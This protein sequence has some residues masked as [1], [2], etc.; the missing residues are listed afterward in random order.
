[1]TPEQ[2]ILILNLLS[3]G[4]LPSQLV[5]LLTLDTDNNY[6]VLNNGL[7]DAKKIKV[8]LLRGF[9]GSY[10]ANTNTPSLTNGV[11][12]DGDMHLVSVAGSR[13]FGAGTVNLL[14]DDIIIYL[15]GKYLKT[16]ANY[17]DQDLNTTNNVTFNS[18][19]TK[20]MTLDVT[21]SPIISFLPNVDVTGQLLL[22]DPL[23]SWADVSVNSNS[24]NV[25]GNSSNRLFLVDAVNSNVTIDDATLTFLEGVHRSVISHGGQTG[26]IALSLP[27]SSGTLALTTAL[28]SYLLLTG[29]TLTGDLNIDDNL[30]TIKL[31]D[32]DNS[33]YGRIRSSNGSLTFEADEG[34][35]QAD[36]FIKFE[37][38]A[39]ERMRIDSTGNV[40]IGADSPDTKLTIENAA[41]GPPSSTY[42]TTVSNA[43]LNLSAVGVP[44]YNHLFMGVGSSTYAWIQSQHGNNVAQNLALNPIGGNV[45]IG[46]DNPDAKLDVNGNILASSI[47]PQSNNVQTIT[48]S[49]SAAT[50]GA[51]INVVVV[52]TTVSCTLTIATTTNIASIKVINMSSSIVYFS[53]GASVTVNDNGDDFVEVYDS[54]TLT[55]IATNSWIISQ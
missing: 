17:F 6:L 40:G 23:L 28:N 55:K 45:G 52:D 21:G 11:G 39:T 33:S 3:N 24:F 38:D 42:A 7:N 29:G 50:I 48:G 27:S 13:D 16:S 49:T 2:L 15:N 12:L 37:I 19:T 43:N 5:E 31:T 10:N 30:P 54:A 4:K 9:K 8:P 14:V 36:S 44:F 32:T 18:V 53:A 41:A 1:M 34:N 47:L 25:Y 22:G 26:D 51:D 20:G 46:T 35:T